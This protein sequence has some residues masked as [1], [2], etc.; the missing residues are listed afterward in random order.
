MDAIAAMPPSIDIGVGGFLG[1]S[2]SVPS[3]GFLSECTPKRSKPG[4]VFSDPT[5]TPLKRQKAS[6]SLSVASPPSGA[7]ASDSESD[8]SFMRKAR[9]TAPSVRACS[10]AIQRKYACAALAA[11]TAK[12]RDVKR[13]KDLRLE[14]GAQ[15]LVAQSKAKPKVP[16][17]KPKAKPKAHPK[18]SPKAPSK[19]KPKAAA[20]DKRVTHTYVTYVFFTFLFPHRAQSFGF[21]IAKP[22]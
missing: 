13:H 19:A 2:S 4:I 9:E 7:D 15:R 20:G 14:L 17:A 21:T 12:D 10:G 6:L 22:F 16:K 1:F 3:I 5:P 11:G 8:A 18:A